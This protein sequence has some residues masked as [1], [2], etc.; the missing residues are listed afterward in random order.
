M[1][2][3]HAVVLHFAELTVVVVFFHEKIYLSMSIKS[4]FGIMVYCLVQ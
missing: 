4:V 3:V 1:S 2:C